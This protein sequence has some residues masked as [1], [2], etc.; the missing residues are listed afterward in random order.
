MVNPLNTKKL[1]ILLPLLASHAIAAD[2]SFLSDDVYFGIKGGYHVLD[3]DKSHPSS[4]DGI[5]LGIYGG[6]RLTDNLSWDLGYQGWEQIEA[7]QHKIDIDM[8]ESALRY[9]AYINK[10]ISLYGRVGAG[11]AFVDSESSQKDKNYD[12]I[13]P[14]A[15]VGVNYWLS[16]KVSA[17][18]S[19]QYIRAIGG[20]DDLDIDANSLNLS[21]TY[22]FDN[23]FK[24]EMIEVT[25][26]KEESF[27]E[28]VTLIE[29]KSTELF[30]FDSYQ[31]KLE[32]K[33]RLLHFVSRLP[34]NAQTVFTITGYTDTSGNE[35]YNM[36][37]SKKRAD[38]VADYL[39][40]TGIKRNTISVVGKG[41]TSPIAT[42]NTFE[43]RRGNRRVEIEAQY[44]ISNH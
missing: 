30:N 8:I 13:S 16:D 20:H 4:P 7:S 25:E 33:E 35:D 6:V 2:S 23:R 1:M 27:V 9:D 26:V 15:E 11:F 12:G 31:L 41:E 22:N 36:R 21:L 40:L 39:V 3:D 29:L 24:H 38:A 10:R 32:G 18:L 28:P 43:G 14:L 37:L 34:N 17:A 42:N 19:Y 5:H 44:S